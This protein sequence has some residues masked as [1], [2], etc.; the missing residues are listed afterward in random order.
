MFCGILVLGLPL[1]VIM[2]SF[3]D[4][5]K[6]AA[7]RKKEKEDRRR[8]K[9][10]DLAAAQTGRVQ[11]QTS[12]DLGDLDVA[13]P[14]RQQ[15]VRDETAAAAAEA[16]VCVL[17]VYFSATGDDR[18]NAAGLCLKPTEKEAAAKARALVRELILSGGLSTE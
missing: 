1:V 18:F 10:E 11:R 4:A 6:N 13:S 8:R 5:F 9:F 14:R 2:T 15:R 3:D 16:V 12:L 17:D 7:R